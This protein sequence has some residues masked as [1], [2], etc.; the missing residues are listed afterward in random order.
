MI[1]LEG[2]EHRAF[3]NYCYALDEEH[4]VISLKTGKEVERVWLLWGD[5]FDQPAAGSSSGC[6]CESAVTERRL[7]QQH[8]WWSITISPRFRRCRYYFRI[9]AGD[10]CFIYGESGLWHESSFRQNPGAYGAFIFPWMNKSDICSPPA[11]AA[12]TIWYQIFPSRFRRGAMEG[13]TEGILPWAGRSEAVTNRQKF[14]GN[15]NGIT[16]KLGYLAQLGISGIYLTPVNAAASQHKYD[17]ADYY[18]IDP[19]LGTKDDMKRLV[20]E[21]HR[22]GIRIMLDGVFN[23]SG[24]EFFA[25]QD[26]LK[27]RQ[28]SRYADWYLVN[29][30]DFPEAAGDNAKNARYFSFG[31]IDHMPKLN[32]NNPEVREYLI[33]ACEYWVREYDIDALRLDV[34]N[35]ICHEFCRELRTR[36]HALKSDFYIVGEIWHNAL[37]WLRGNEFDAVMNYP[38]QNAICSFAFDSRQHVQ[39]FAHAVNRCLTDYFRQ[40]QKV[41]FNL[42]DSHDTERLVSR[43]GS[44][45]KALQLLA[46]MFALPGAPCLYYGTEIF[47]EGGKDPD[48]RRCMPWQEIESGSCDAELQAVQ[49]LIALRRSRPELAAI[50]TECLSG[51][52]GGTDEGRRLLLKKTL[53][54]GSA[55]LLFIANFGTEAW[56]ISPHLKAAAPL[57]SAGLDGTVLRPD[58]FAFIPA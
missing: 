49:Q 24:R 12:D 33:R 45:Q 13:N 32:T 6:I 31:Y 55:A 39:D 34:A 19:E 41:M 46:L 22:R 44:R 51:E 26:V 16:E 29:E 14:G 17:T 10:E 54:D 30:W 37:P 27:H 8:A 23:H 9:C 38:L 20:Q 5:P 36:M 48:C 40:T 21:A 50:R 25:W 11:W 43:A 3:D 1:S 52:G 35:E 56:D 58:G 7:L 57:F 4:L 47:L 42:L 15:L 2:I 53:D 28:Q 18:T